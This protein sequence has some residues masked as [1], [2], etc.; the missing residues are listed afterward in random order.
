MRKTSG[1]DSVFGSVG[2]GVTSGG[3]NRR[4]RAGSLQDR[5]GV[6]KRFASP[7]R[8]GSDSPASSSCRQHF[9]ES[10]L[11]MAKLGASDRGDSFPSP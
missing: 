2:P 3:A 1:T 5:E 9:A 7:P 6:N 4:R 11:A 8:P 10:L